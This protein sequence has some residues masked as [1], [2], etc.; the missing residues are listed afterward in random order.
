[1]SEKTFK[2]VNGDISDG[3]HTFDELYEHRCLLYIAWLTSAATPS[4]P[5]V[6]LDHYKGWD[7]LVCNLPGQGQISYHVP[8][9]YRELYRYI[10]VANEGVHEWDGH[11]SQDVLSRIEKWIAGDNQTVS[12][13]PQ[14]RE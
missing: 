14:E 8:C 7:L 13:K 3:Y 9:K 10:K 2:I 12:D 5:Y 6:V 1:M 11:T 4:D